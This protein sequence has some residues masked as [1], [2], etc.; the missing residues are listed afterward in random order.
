[1]RTLLYY[2]HHFYFT[3]TRDAL[4][5]DAVELNVLAS[6]TSWSSRNADA[7][8]IAYQQLDAVDNV[9]KK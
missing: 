1:M 2:I 8:S 5:K 7:Q 4:R 9:K 3:S 6:L